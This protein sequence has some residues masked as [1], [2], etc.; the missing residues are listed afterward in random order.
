MI[1]TRFPTPWYRT[2]IYWLCWLLLMALTIIFGRWS[3]A[4]ETV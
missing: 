4:R 3:R 2:P 1:I